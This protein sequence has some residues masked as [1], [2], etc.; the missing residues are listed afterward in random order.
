[1][2]TNETNRKKRVRMFLVCLAC[3][4]LAVA[5]K[6][7]KKP[8]ENNENPTPTEEVTPT[9][10][11]TPTPEELSDYD[12]MISNSLIQTGNNY[13]IKNA[14]EKAKNGEDVTIAYIGGSITEGAGATS[15]NNCYAYQSYLAF[16]EAYGKDGGEN[17][18]FVNAGMSGTPSSLGVIR[19]KRDVLDR[20]ETAPDIVFVEFAVNDGDDVTN[21]DT[22]ES[23]V[24]NILNADNQPA[25]ILLF[26][27]FQSQWNL[28]E[29][30][31]P[32]GKVYKLPMVS[33][34]NAIIPEINAG[35]LTNEEFF[36]ADTL[37]PVDNGHKIM[38]DCITYLFT[39][40][41]AEEKAASDITIPE[42]FY[43]GNS[44]EG[45]QMV[46]SKSS[47]P[48][49]T[50]NAGGFSTQDTATGTFICDDTPKFENTWKHAANA[51]G[52]SFTMEVTCKN[53]LFVYKL[54]NS[55]TA[56]KAEIYVDG[57]LV[58]TEDSFSSGGWNN[59]KTVSIINKKEA[60]KH[61]I[62]IKMAAGDEGKEF[63][64][65]GFGFAE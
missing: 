35:K 61:T 12:R 9:E 23:L 13:R 54:C 36:S 41:A 24:R 29:R 6:Q 31:T 34:K 64:I 48:G 28:Q 65:L 46:D 63:T 1:M 50:V 4:S 60:A 17:V 2:R 20:A 21:G 25:V 44:Y 7:E 55:N 26:S 58:S 56:G 52:D 30:F 51:S 10:E 14:M 8:D 59:P 47:I 27:V 19:Y 33:I 18:H 57:E 38:S 42:K 11:A 53:M 62:E 22:Y 5:C 40:I 39:K 32:I 49:V 37:H 43:I 16:K 15:H 3:L 45:I